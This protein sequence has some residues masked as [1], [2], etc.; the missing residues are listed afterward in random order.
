MAVD[1]TK[2]NAMRPPWFSKR[3]GEERGRAKFAP[4]LRR[5]GKRGHKE[6]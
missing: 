3:G 2:E 6:A 4:R 5:R 1:G